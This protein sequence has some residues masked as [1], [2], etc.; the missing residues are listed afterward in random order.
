MNLVMKTVKRLLREAPFP[1]RISSSA[2]AL[3]S[4]AA[5]LLG[6]T[7]ANA[8][9]GLTGIGSKSPIRLPMLVQAGNDQDED[10][11]SDLGVSIV[12]LWHVVYTAGGSTFNETLDQW[13]SD[14]TEFENAWLP[15]D[16]GNICF[17]VWKEVAP[18]TVRLH[19]I[20]WLFTPGST[21]PTASGTFTLDETNVVSRDGESY[22]G[23]FTFKTFDS[24]GAPT[25]I[26]VTGTIAAT[27][28]TVD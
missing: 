20:G 27:R 22:T 2:L 3:L 21:P 23:N 24:T 13:H 8:A 19:H 14:G 7:S 28:I 1:I 4:I 16:T 12:G 6:A 9:C 25:G 5:L 26:E 17:G 10:A 18:R 15:P 11:A